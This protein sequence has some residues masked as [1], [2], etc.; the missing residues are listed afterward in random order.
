MISFAGHALTRVIAR[1]GM[2]DIYRARPLDE[3]AGPWR[4]VKLM[5]SSVDHEALRLRL[6]AREMKIAEHLVH[7]NIVRVLGSGTE[8]GRPYLLMD[9]VGGRDAESFC[10]RTRGAPLPYELA[11]ALGAQAARGLGHAHRVRHTGMKLGIVHRDVSPGNIRIGWDGTVKVLD[12]GV[13]RLLHGG[14]P[15]T[16][17]GILRGK[18]AYMSP[19]QARGDPID[20]RSDVFSL[21]VVLYELIV[22]QPAF[23][24]E[25]PIDTLERIRNMRLTLPSQAR[26][27][28]SP[29]VDEI[30]A[31]ALAKDPAF[32][33]RDGI[34]MAEAFEHFLKR[35]RFEG[36]RAWAEYLATVHS[37]EYAQ[38]QAMLDEEEG[39]LRDAMLRPEPFTTSPPTSGRRLLGQSVLEP[40][41]VR[42]TTRRPRWLLV[43]AGILLLLAG[44][45]GVAVSR[46]SSDSGV[47]RLAPVPIELGP[48]DSPSP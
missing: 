24:G 1:G 6:F 4:A 9:Y 14:D 46:R 7:P 19:E 17:T 10:A 26:S 12:F 16:Q 8:E 34:H 15:E 21:G 27:G 44:A 35:R 31:R 48:E 43:L 11:L 18:F 38:E 28:I 36:R 5:R 42:R 3:P 23:R 25:G 22:G 2:A 33:Y 29:E 41:A 45:W 30:L 32:R 39:W 47:R 40:S 13:A 20:P 37:K